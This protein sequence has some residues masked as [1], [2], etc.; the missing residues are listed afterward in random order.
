MLCEWPG[1]HS[2]Q[3]DLHAPG[4]ICRIM[5]SAP[6]FP[7]WLAREERKADRHGLR[8][9]GTATGARTHQQP[10]EMIDLSPLGCRLRVAEPMTVGSYITLASAGAPRVEGWVAW[11]RA[12]ECGIDFAHPMPDLIAEH[13]GNPAAV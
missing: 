7:H 10:V 5:A 9:T 11:S 4:A 6:S 2:P 13:I 12:T 3:D 8:L 1:N